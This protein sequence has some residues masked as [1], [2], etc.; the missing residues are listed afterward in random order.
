MFGLREGADKEGGNFYIR[1]A[2]FVVLAI[3]M[4]LH[5]VELGQ[6]GTCLTPDELH[7]NAV[8]IFK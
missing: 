4:Q 7:Q 8:S 1:G 2:V 3:V 6:A 5:L